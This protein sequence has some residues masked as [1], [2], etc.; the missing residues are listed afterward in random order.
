MLAP[1]LAVGLVRGALHLRSE[2]WFSVFVVACRGLLGV[3]SAWVR[4]LVGGQRLRRLPVLRW[5]ICC[6]LS[7]G[8]GAATFLVS[9]FWVA[10]WGLQSGNP[11]PLAYLFAGIVGLILL[12]GT[13][14]LQRAP[15]I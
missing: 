5:A 10:G 3:A 12:V 13:V 6:G 11:V 1:M 15:A 9:G 2:G 4:V 7:V 8:I 14:W